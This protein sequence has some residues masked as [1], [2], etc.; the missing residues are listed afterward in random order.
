M[1]DF[2]NDPIL[3]HTYFGSRRIIND[4]EK[5]SDF[6]KSNVIYL[7]AIKNEVLKDADG[8]DIGIKHEAL[9]T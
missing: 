7:D 9:V 2:R 6:M 5:I 3:R 1:E 8:N 4:V